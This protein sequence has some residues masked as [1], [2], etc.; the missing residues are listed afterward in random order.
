VI[1][2]N[3][4]VWRNRMLFSQTDDDMIFMLPTVFISMAVEGH[5]I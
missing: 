1:S 2:G 3:K 4:R 5:C